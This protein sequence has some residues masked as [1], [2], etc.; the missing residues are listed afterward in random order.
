LTNHHN[1][2]SYSSGGIS[3][4]LIVAILLNILI[5]VAQVTGGIASGSLSLISDA[6]HNFSDVIALII[7]YIASILIT[8]KQTVHKTFGYKRAEIIAAFVNTLALIT[9]AVLLATESLKRFRNPIEISSEYVIIL[10]GIAIFFNGFSALILWKD[11]ADNLNIQSSY[12]HLLTDMFTSVAVLA[13]GIIM[14]Y[15]KIFWIDG[16]LTLLIASY[17]IYSSVKL[18]METLK[19]LML[20]TPS[21]II[22]NDINRII[23]SIPEVQN[24]H[25]I[26]VWQ[27]DNRQI[28]FEGHV[29]FNDNLP[30][31]KVN[32]VLEEI[33]IIL[34]NQ[35]NIEHVTLQ[36]EFE[37]DHKKDL[38]SEGH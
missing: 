38:I 12:L 16:A 37:I 11:A 4:K 32:Q 34:I 19:V 1:I 30:L 8:K 29:D 35:F 10:S 25:H 13:G 9:V 15:F 28:H 26:H 33:R 17:L 14:F 23:C 3:K 20:F 22:I 18:L 5:T 2:V 31:S 7:S 6:L 36:P 21:S 24:I 27:L